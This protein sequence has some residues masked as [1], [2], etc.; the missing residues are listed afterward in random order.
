MTSRIQREIVELKNLLLQMSSLAEESVRSSVRAWQ[1]YDK[2]LAKRVID[3]DEEIDK[4]DL[5]IDNL[6]IKTLALQQPMAR[7]LRFLTAAQQISSQLERVGDH[8]VNIAKQ[9]HSLMEGDE[10][11]SCPAP[12]LNEMAGI[13]IHMLADSINSFVYEDSD[14][15]HAVITKDTDADSLYSEVVQAEIDAMTHDRSAV[16]CGVYHII[17]AL[18]MERIADLATN[19]AEEVI[20]LVEGR[21]IR[22]G[23]LLDEEAVIDRP[24]V[25]SRAGGCDLHHEHHRPEPLECL[26]NHAETVHKCLVTAADA[27]RTYFNREHINFV[28]LF[29]EVSHLEHEADLVKRNVRA[30]LPKGIIMPIDK[31]ELF[32]YLNEQDAIA[33]TA[34]TM[35]EWITYRHPQIPSGIKQG[36]FDLMDKCLDTSK[37]LPQLLHAARTYFHTGDEDVRNHVKEGIRKIRS[38]EHDADVLEHDLKRSLFNAE[39][40]PI[41]L[42]YL[43]R[44][45]DLIGSSADHAENAVDILRSMIAR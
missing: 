8:S 16:K 19:I 34:E 44:L 27:V 38:R 40:D 9:V 35:L 12:G 23:G 14:L 29:D 5:E 39:L 6:V 33:G 21:V 45:V 11:R 18:N 15:A 25:S 3:H 41:S 43:L 26:E 13:A 36:I 32:F 24:K 2:E 1:H 30:H 10:I 37:N 28:E 7:D 4:L 42:L 31:F 20:F 17:L 22:H